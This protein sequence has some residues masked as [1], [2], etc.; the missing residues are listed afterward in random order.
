MNVALTVNGI[1]LL[2]PLCARLFGDLTFGAEAAEHA[3]WL[4]AVEGN[5][6]LLLQTGA[7]AAQ[8]AEVLTT[9]RAFTFRLCTLDLLW[10]LTVQH[11]TKRKKKKRDLKYVIVNIS[12]HKP[13][14][15]F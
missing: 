8:S 7:N 12:A 2:T 5:S 11:L 6:A 15:A 10:E 14:S 9:F 13:C 3:L 4:A 1:I